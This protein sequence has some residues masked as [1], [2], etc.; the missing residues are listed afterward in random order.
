MKV[1]IGCMTESTVGISAI[2]QFLPL[3]DYV[4]M[5]GA[6]LIA[7]DVATGV[8]LEKGRAVFPDENGNGVRLLENGL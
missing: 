3:L 1:M 4:D 6:V 8:R 5:D 7:K 2:A